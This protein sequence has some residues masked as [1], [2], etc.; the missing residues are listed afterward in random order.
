MIDKK[1]RDPVHGFISISPAELR[2]IDSPVF[3]RM[4]GIKQLSLGVRVQVL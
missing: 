1:F 2:I 4:R 3:Q